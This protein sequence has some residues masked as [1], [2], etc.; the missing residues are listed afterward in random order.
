MTDRLLGRRIVAYSIDAT[1]SCALL[2]SSA[3]CIGLAV[4]LS[5]DPDHLTPL[6]V[7]L[8]AAG[9]LL[10]TVT[11]FGY[12]LLKDVGRGLVGRR[13]SGTRVVHAETGLPCTFR[14]SLVR[15]FVLLVIGSVD[16]II[17]I[18]R[19]SGLR[20]GDDVAK[21]RVVRGQ[22]PVGVTDHGPRPP[23]TASS[24]GAA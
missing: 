5:D 9:L 3:C 21:T 23:S 4:A 11:G 10:A 13:L 19:A 7:V 20:L 14:Q 24:S 22:P 18:V 2:S 1:I 8:C 12:F 17:P 6:G 15:N 16:L